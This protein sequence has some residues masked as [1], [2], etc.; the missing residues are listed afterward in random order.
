METKIISEILAKRLRE[1]RL[2]KG[3]SQ[4]EIANT[5]NISQPSYIRYELKTGEPS[6]ATLVKL[7]KYYQVTVGYL[8]GTEDY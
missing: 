4:R 1:L 3:L 5:L 2:E 6:L 8:L 7:S